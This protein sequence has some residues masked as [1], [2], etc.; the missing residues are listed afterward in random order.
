MI[1]L[2]G[3][4]V[5]LGIVLQLYALFDCARTDQEAVQK[6]PKWGW[7]I[8]ILLFG[9][10]GPIAWLVVGRPRNGGGRGPRRGKPR[11][12]PPDDDPDFLRKL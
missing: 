6:L 7:L 2:E 3:F 11:I 10:I 12:I 1:K 8:V 9:L 4:I 5:V